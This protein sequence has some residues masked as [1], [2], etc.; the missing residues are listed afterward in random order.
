MCQGLGWERLPWRILTETQDLYE[1]NPTPL[2]L[3]TGPQGSDQGDFLRFEC[4]HARGSLGGNV[5][6]T[7]THG[8]VYLIN[9]QAPEIGAWVMMPKNIRKLPSVSQ[10]ISC[11]QN[12]NPGLGE[13]DAFS[14]D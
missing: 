3:Q 14:R 6:N 1:E 5:L 11:E 10:R 2:P 7:H 8:L 4:I 9:S 12:L 13:A